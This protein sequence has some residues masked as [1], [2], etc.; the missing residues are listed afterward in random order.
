MHKYS[1]GGV[2]GGFQ[3]RPIFTS[4]NTR[5]S[6]TVESSSTASLVPSLFPGG[7]G[8]G[9]KKTGYEAIL[10]QQETNT[11][12]RG[13]TSRPSLSLSVLFRIFANSRRWS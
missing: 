9:K 7:E 13:R 12:K 4:S 2:S 5:P 3:T 1:R 10:V 8:K 6:F 11:V